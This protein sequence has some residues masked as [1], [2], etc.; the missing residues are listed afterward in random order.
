MTGILTGAVMLNS[1][2]SS[3]PSVDYTVAIQWAYY[4][5]ILLSGLCILGALIGRQFTES[6]QLAKVRE[7]DR[8]MRIGYPAFIGAVV[9]GYLIAF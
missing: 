9:I 1:V 7:L 8:V 3:L 4:A 2:T 6:R 5:F